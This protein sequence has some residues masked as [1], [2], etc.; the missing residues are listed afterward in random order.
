MVISHKAQY[1]Y[2]NSSA[3]PVGPVSG[4]VVTALWGR[5]SNRTSRRKSGGEIFI[6][7]DA[8]EVDG[9]DFVERR[10]AR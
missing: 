10:K 8:N 3:F 2:P 5:A 9:L 7:K 6:S 4:D 1:V